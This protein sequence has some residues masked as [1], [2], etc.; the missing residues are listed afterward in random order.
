MRI[1]VNLLVLSTLLSGC[2][3]PGTVSRNASDAAITECIDLMAQ[4]NQRI[5]DAKVNDAQHARINSFPYLRVN[6]FLS[7]FRLQSFNPDAFHFWLDQMQSLTLAD[8]QIELANLD[9]TNRQ[10]IYDNYPAINNKQALLSSLDQCSHTLR[11]SDFHDNANKARLIDLAVVPDSYNTWQ[12]AIGLY[13]LTAWFFRAGIY[14]WHQETQTVFNQALSELPVKGTLQR[15]FYKINNNSNTDVAGILKHSNHNPLSIPLPS[16]KQ[17]EQLF[18]YF[19]PVFEIDSVDNNDKIGRIKLTQDATPLVDTSIAQVYRHVSRTHLNK[20]TLLQLNYTIWFPARPKTSN[21]DLL[22]GQIDG[23]TWRVTLSTDGR[24]LVF[25]TMHN[26]GCYHLFFPTQFVEQKNQSLSLSE[27]AFIPQSLHWSD[28]KRVVVRIASGNHYIQ[29]VSLEDKAEVTGNHA[30]QLQELD[31]LRSLPVNQQQHQSLYDESG[32][33]RSSLR[34]ERYLFW[35]MGI[36]EPGAMR[37]WGT[38][39]TAFTGKRHFDDARL[40]ER[41]FIIKAEIQ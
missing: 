34:G 6:R 21:W 13:P 36:T 12:R 38:H 15:Y 7:E 18:D 19:A 23:I 14:D 5:D 41:Y 11:L 37:Q 16:E 26:C 3:L 4:V 20:Q 10:F 32:I 35:P 25:D 24:P 9:I 40:L 31:T 29:R 22:G 33:I 2:S 28:E 27:P 1:V 8:W 17:L 30:Y 39:A